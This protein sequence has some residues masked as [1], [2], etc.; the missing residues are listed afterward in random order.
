M[1][2]EVESSSSDAIVKRWEPASF[3]DGQGGIQSRSTDLLSSETA[4]VVIN[5]PI[6]RKDIFSTLWASG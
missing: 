4:L 6:A 5:T 1:G 3:F 2:M